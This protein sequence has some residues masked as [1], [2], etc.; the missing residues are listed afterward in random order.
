ML[1]AVFAAAAAAVLIAALRPLSPPHPFAASRLLLVTAHPDDECLFFAPTLLTLPDHQHL[2]SL[3]LSIGNADGLGEVRKRELQDS[4]DVL[5]IARDRRWV[6]DHPLLQDNITQFWDA[7]VV[8]HVLRPYVLEHK[9]DTIL[10]FDDRGVSGHPN[11]R[12]LP[13]GVQQ[14]IDSW[15]GVPRPRL[16]S[17]VSVPLATKYIGVLSALIAKLKGSEQV[18]VAGM[19]EY[20]QAVQAMRRHSSQMR[21]FRYLYVLHS[22][23]MWV[24]EWCTE[25]LKN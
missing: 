11:H 2:Y 15:D 10:T 3:T 5:G 12:S 16:F 18:F 1:P 8:A 13:S 7:D 21:W 23:Y 22:R 6:V 25:T 14:L 24:N 17:L 20:W 9:I 4:L 19:G